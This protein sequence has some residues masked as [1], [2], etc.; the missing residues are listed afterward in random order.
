MNGGGESDCCVQKMEHVVRETLMHHGIEPSDSL[1]D[2]CFKRLCTITETF[3]RV[4]WLPVSLLHQP[5]LV[6]YN[7]TSLP[8]SALEVMFSSAFL[9]LVC[10]FVN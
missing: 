10:L 1:F 4:C 7:A 8:L 6:M 5:V 3:V 9:K 2:T